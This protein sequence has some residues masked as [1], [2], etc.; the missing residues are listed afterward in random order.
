MLIEID[1]A[2]SR[3]QLAHGWS[4]GMYWRAIRAAEISGLEYQELLVYVQ[5]LVPDSRFDL[6]LRPLG[7]VGGLP[8]LCNT[9][10]GRKRDH[11]LSLC[12]VSPMSGGFNAEFRLHWYETYY[13]TQCLDRT[14]RRVREA[15][16]L[17]S[18][19]PRRVT[20]CN[21][22]VYVASYYFMKRIQPAARHICKCI[23]KARSQPAVAYSERDLV[24]ARLAQQR[25]G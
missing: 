1:R 7:D 25:L 3:F 24:L 8:P 4:H 14:T 19:Y 6:R 10:R 15:A 13:G 18:W 9:D 23:A 20:D 17:R 11:G 12:R 2:A 21:R 16:M 22:N 5:V